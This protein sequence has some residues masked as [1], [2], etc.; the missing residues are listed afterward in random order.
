MKLSKLLLAALSAMVL[1]SALVS[2]ASARNLSSSSQTLRSQFREVRFALP[3]GTVNCQV[4]LEGSLHAR[5]IA[6]VAGSLIGY[7]TAARLGPCSSGRATILTETLPWHARYKS[8][9]GTLPNITS[10]RIDV[11]NASFRV[12]EGFIFNCLAR[13]T[14]AEPAIGTFNREAGGALTSAEIG[15]TIRTGSECFEEAG[16]FTSDRGT[17]TVLNSSTRIT[18]TL[19]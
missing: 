19:I 6:K 17:V 18:V 13:S 16:S 3:F 1:L 9:A 14:A 5:T 4:T 2:S 11:I 12:A 10:V 8:F 15:G 7:I